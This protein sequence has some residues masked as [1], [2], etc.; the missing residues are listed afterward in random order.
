[1]TP[2]TPATNPAIACALSP[3]ELETRADRLSGLVGEALTSIE[4]DDGFALAFAG[5]EETARRLFDFVIA[6][7]RCCPF[8]RFELVFEPNR[9]PVRLHLLGSEEVKSF[10]R[11]FL[12]AE[13]G[14]S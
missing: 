1:M 11:P 12:T 14:A 2:E 5:D 3:A 6:E 4:L 13:G 10:A 9:G 7:R 8:F